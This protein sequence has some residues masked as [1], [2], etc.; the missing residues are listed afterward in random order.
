MGTLLGLAVRNLLRNKSRTG[1]TAG[2]IAFGVMMTVVLGGFVTGIGDLIVD[3]VVK[4]KIGAIQVHLRGYDDA[5]EN[6]PIHL[7]MPATGEILD[8]IR[9]VPGVVAVTPRVV[10]AAMANNG[11]NS[12]MVIATGMDPVLEYEALP[13]AKWGLVGEPIAADAP[14]RGVLGK[15]LADAM[16]AATGST[17]SLTAATLGGQQNALDLDV[18]GTVNNATPL[19]SK[20]TLAVPLKWAQELLQLEDRAT[21][22]AVAVRDRKDVHAIADAMAAKLGPEYHVQTWDQLRPNAADI[23]QVQRIVLF[24]ICIV[25]LVIAIIGVMNT[26]LMSVLERTREIGTMMA[27]GVKRRT[28]VALFLFEAAA[29]AVIGMAGGAGIGFTL[30]G[31]VRGLGGIPLRPPGSAS[32]AHVMPAVPGWLIATALVAMVVGTMA[33][34]AYPTWRASRLRPVEALRAV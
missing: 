11:T 34:A 23:T 24:A 14:H 20:R 5:K 3:G 17:V 30:Q 27:V 32:V 1:L 21:E 19:E 10:F 7:N 31:I 28:I 12:T 29:L 2:A 4:V 26:L 15:E 22:F 9:S 8:K 18:G 6:L 33:A 16:G 25:F 13:S